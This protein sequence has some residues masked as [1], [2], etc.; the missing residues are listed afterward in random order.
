[1]TQLIIISIYLALLLG[2]GF[3]SSKLFRGTSKDYMLASHSIGPFM[4]LMSLFGTT[5]TAFALVGSTG[6]SFK[7][8][9]GVYGLLASSS[10]I[11]HS[12]CFFVLGVKLW[13]L[14]KKHG[15]T[16][17]IQFFRD[18]LE[19]DR[20]GILLFP[21]LVGLIIPYLLIG[22][23]A[24][25]TVINSITEG[26]F[27]TAFAQYDYGV[28]PWLASLVICLV[29]LIYVFFGGMRGTAI[30]N[31]AQTIV[32][33]IL[34][35]ITFVI[36]SD[37]L[38]GLEEST[39]K[40]LAKNPSKMIRSVDPQDTDSYE[41]G[42]KKWIVLAQYEYAKKHKGLALDP[43]DEKA[44]IAAF[45]I[46]GPAGYLKKTRGPAIFAKKAGLLSNLSILDQNLALLIQ[47]NR[48]EIPNDKGVLDNRISDSSVMA[49][50]EIMSFPRLPG[51]DR[52]G[53]T[54]FAQFVG[55]PTEKAASGK[56]TKW[57]R[58]KAKGV[59]RATHWAPDPPH[60]MDPWKFLTYFFVPLSV[61]MFPHLFQH[62]LTAKSAASFKLAVV[63]HPI[64]I[65]I[66]WVPCVLLGVW[67]TSATDP[68]SGAPIIAAH[69]PPNAVLPAAVKALTGPLMAG[70]LTAGILAAIMSSLD[71]QFLCVGTMFTTD[72]VSHYAGKN[73]F[74]DKQLITIARVFIVLIVALTY[75][76]SLFEPRRVFTLGVWCFSGFSSLFP[77]ILASLYWKRLTKLGAYAAILAAA[78]SWIYMFA[79]AN[80]AANA[81]YT[82]FG[83]MPVATMI[84]LT[85]IAM[86]VVSL[87]TPPPS[88]ETLE[89]FFPA[90][91]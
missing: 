13:S 27:T 26:A 62:W 71:S 11:I 50:H 12:L 14:G 57:T 25:G 44:A 79:D 38:G 29:V 78:G 51:A 15:Y 22:V 66:V 70:L 1:M 91:K 17:Q 19:S 34:G 49:H 40:V 83:V 2:L 59:F 37:K 67:M 24:S 90:E 9:A 36:V 82:V 52:E 28:P 5:M 87:I 69:F 77:L 60:G 89:K 45:P 85:T 46:A 7:E 8:G 42:Y 20:I 3:F 4:L 33:M 65:M 74:T 58:K 48:Y 81:N 56:G 64:F 86:I 23:M 55:H 41:D 73:R 63:A 10:G 16:T 43:A 88:K 61:G 76:F 21:I 30:A 80:Y 53:L 54:I 84:T 75:L 6:E 18:R 39:N 31:T 47:D 72:I 68:I 32:F 35:L